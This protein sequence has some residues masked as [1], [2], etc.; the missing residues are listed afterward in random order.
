MDNVFSIDSIE[1]GIARLVP[2][3]GASVH[4]LAQKLP[5]DAAA[6]DRVAFR[7]GKWTVLAEE[8]DAL[9]AELFD[10]QES[11]FDE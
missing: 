1:S 8:T 9:R 11:L 10:L 2:E 6:G 4:I 3:E 7:G 5:Q